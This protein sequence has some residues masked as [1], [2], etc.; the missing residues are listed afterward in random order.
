MPCCSDIMDP[1]YISASLQGSQMK[2]L[3]LWQGILRTDIKHLIYHTFSGHSHKNLR[4][5]SI[6]TTDITE[7]FKSAHELIVLVQSLGKAEAGV[8][9]PSADAM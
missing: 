5:R 8:K 7:L 1:E 6:F 9:H 3:S 4:N 2:Y